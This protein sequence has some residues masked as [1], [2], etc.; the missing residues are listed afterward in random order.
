MLVCAV[1]RATMIRRA[2][3]EVRELSRSARLAFVMSG[4]QPSRRAQRQAVSRAVS[5]DR[6]RLHRA[7]SALV[8]A[9]G[10]GVPVL[11]A[12]DD[13]HWA[14]PASTE[15]LLYLLRR[16]PSTNLTVAVTFRTRQLK[17]ATAT[18]LQQVQ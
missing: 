13:L 14:D 7:V 5:G 3:A 1:H 11:L 2:A 15:L 17:P 10:E 4:E 16:P 8:E 9:L 6:Y 12:V 18:V